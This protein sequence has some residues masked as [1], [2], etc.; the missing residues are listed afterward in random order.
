MSNLAQITREIRWALWLTVAYII[1]W[2][3][4]AYFSP[5]G[6]GVLGFPIWFE[7]ACLYLPLLFS[8]ATYVVIKRC[9]KEIDLENTDE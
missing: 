3:G 2:V 8:L 9:F 6:K 4:F 1:G 5:E 7:L